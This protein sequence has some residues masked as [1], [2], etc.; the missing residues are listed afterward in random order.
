MNYCSTLQLIICHF[1]QCRLCQSNFTVLNREISVLDN[2]FIMTLG[3]KTRLNCIHYF[4]EVEFNIVFAE[5][6]S[7][8]EQTHLNLM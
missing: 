4:V 7:C 6:L 2:D 3:Y 5:L 1:L 8:S